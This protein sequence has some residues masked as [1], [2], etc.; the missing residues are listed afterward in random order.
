MKKW[1][2]KDFTEFSWKYWEESKMPLFQLSVHIVEITGIHS[3]AF[4]WQKIRENN[5][6]AKE[7]IKW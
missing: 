7:I 1:K 3:H 2:K 6:F 5:A 4:F